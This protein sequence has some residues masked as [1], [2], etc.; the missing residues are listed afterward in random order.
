M[1]VTL[2]EDHAAD[3]EARAGPPSLAEAASHVH[4]P[5]SALRDPNVKRRQRALHVLGSSGNETT[6]QRVAALLSDPDSSV[7]HAAARALGYMGVLVAGPAALSVLRSSDA[8]IARDAAG[9]ALGVMGDRI[10][11]E[12]AALLCDDDEIVRAGATRAI[13]IALR[14]EGG[15]GAPVARRCVDALGKIG[16]EPIANCVVLLIGDPDWRIRQ[17]ASRVLSMVGNRDATSAIASFLR[18]PACSKDARSAAAHALSAMGEDVVP[19][20]LAL[21]ED[22]GEEVKGAAG[23]AIERMAKAKS[24]AGTSALAAPTSENPEALA[25]AHRHPNNEVRKGSAQM[26]GR[27]GEAAAPALLELLTDNDAFVR[28]RA[29]VSLGEAMKQ[30]SL[31]AHTVK[32]APL[33]KDTDGFSRQAAADT[34]AKVGEPAMPH[35]ASLLDSADWRTR[36]S[37]ARAFK[38]MDT[39]VGTR[40][41]EEANRQRGGAAM[42]ASTEALRQ[43]LNSGKAPSVNE[44]STLLGNRATHVRSAAAEIV[45]GMGVGAT[46]HVEDLAQLLADPELGPRNAAEYALIRLGRIAA[47]AVCTMLGHYDSNVRATSSQVLLEIG[48][49]AV[50][51][52]VLLL[53]DRV[54]HTPSLAA[55]AAAVAIGCPSKVFDEAAAAAIAGMREDREENVRVA[56]GKALKFLAHSGFLQV[57]G[58]DSD[59]WRL[60]PVHGE[61]SLT[62][63]SIDC[64]LKG[65]ASRRL[66]RES[67][68]STGRSTNCPD[69]AE[70][71]LFYLTSEGDTSSSWRSRRHAGSIRRNDGTPYDHTFF[72]DKKQSKSTTC[73]PSF[74]VTEFQAVCFLKDPQTLKT[75]HVRR[76]A[77][78]LLGQSSISGGPDRTS[79]IAVLLKD[80]DAY[81]RRTAAEML[82]KMGGGYRRALCAD[83]I[84]VLLK[85]ADGGVRSAAAEALGKLSADGLRHATK[86]A[87]LLRDKQEYVRRSAAMSLGVMADSSVAHQVV[88]YLKDVLPEVRMAAAN[89]FRE[90]GGAGAAYSSDVVFTLQDTCR[91]VRLAASEALAQMGETGAAATVA[92]LEHP[93]EHVRD[94]AS[95]ALGAMGG[96]CAGDCVAL[97]EHRE[98]HVRCASL[99]ALA[100]MGEAAASHAAVI[101]HLIDRPRVVGTKQDTWAVRLAAAQALACM[102]RSASIHAPRL[103]LLLYDREGSVRAAAADAISKLLPHRQVAHQAGES[104]ESMQACPLSARSNV[105]STTGSWKQQLST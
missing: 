73:A 16:G 82:G 32:L 84:A 29:A 5:E 88:V 91:D 89:A 20:L 75:P 68:D 71:R 97:L 18:S 28:G 24:S 90:M 4:D 94:A 53:S 21:L 65:A 34:L 64:P 102:G 69:T 42:V 85:D 41:L 48:E 39:H 13:T 72:P 101:A 37:A 3:M 30:E 51:H 74:G 105:A 31:S 99:A 10:V 2:K 38:V 17:R 49:S 54:G 50:P 57:S 66:V 77:A 93:Q 104:M 86:V 83:A 23:H 27:M 55:S 36:R 9:D 62:A 14:D 70:S 43:M 80:H 1:V 60:P 56:A 81:T 40:C 100:G 58:V 63:R 12:L 44:V 59:P 11:P 26:L 25:K 98:S 103:S 67:M 7:R 78:Q 22:E 19:G 87:A 46:P 79:E 95:H 47:P 15:L 35:I 6:A 96:A 61:G 45:A 33:L 8:A 52:L 76:A 92:L